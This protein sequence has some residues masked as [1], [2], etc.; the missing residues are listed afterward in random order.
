MIS[1]GIRGLRTLICLRR[2]PVSGTDTVCL[3]I[4]NWGFKS[5]QHMQGDFSGGL[6]LGIRYVFLNSVPENFIG[7]SVSLTGFCGVAHRSIADFYEIIVIKKR[8]RS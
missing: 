7:L 1:F 8:D 5:S 2:P 3:C 6:N 4:K